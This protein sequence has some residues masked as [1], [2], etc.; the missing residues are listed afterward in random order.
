M[1]PH[2]SDH[3]NTPADVKQEKVSVATM[4]L[5]LITV[6]GL[7]LAH[8]ESSR[9]LDYNDHSARYPFELVIVGEEVALASALP[10][11]KCISGIDNIRQGVVSSNS[12]TTGFRVPLFVL[13]AIGEANTH[14]RHFSHQHFMAFNVPHQNADDDAF[15]F[16]VEVA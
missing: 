13:S 8:L 9:V 12:W 14:P 16:P 15:I 6:T 10:V 5:L 1:P 4:F 11:S 3:M 7:D 2:A